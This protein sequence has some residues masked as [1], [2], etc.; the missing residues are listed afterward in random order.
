MLDGTGFGDI[1]CFGDYDG[2]ELSRE[3]RLVIRG[4]KVAA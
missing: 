1:A 2:G 4:R 3:T